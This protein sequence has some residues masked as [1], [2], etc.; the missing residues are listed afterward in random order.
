MRTFA[1]IGEK[2]LDILKFMVRPHGQAGL[3]QCEDIVNKGGEGS[4]FRDFV[5]TSFMD[6]PLVVRLGNVCCSKCL[7]NHAQTKV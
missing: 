7:K 6:G 5:L 4:I 1:L 3:S 2:T